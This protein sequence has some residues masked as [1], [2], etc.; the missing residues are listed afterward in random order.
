MGITSNLTHDI[1]FG[2]LLRSCET[3]IDYRMILLDGLK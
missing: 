3:F 1:N 2:T